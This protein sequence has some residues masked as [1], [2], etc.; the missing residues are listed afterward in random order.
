[1]NTIK[2]LAATALLAI[3]TQAAAVTYD[4]SFTHSTYQVQEGNSIDDLVAAHLAGSALTNQSLSGFDGIETTAFIAGNAYDHSIMMSTSFT[5]AE[6][7]QYE[8]QVGA[9]WGRGGGVAI[10]NDDTNSLVS[11]QIF[12]NDI[13]WSKNWNNSD[14]ISTNFE[15]SEGNWK[16][17]WVG[18]EGCCSG[19]TSIRFA[20]NGG[21]FSAL[22]AANFQQPHSAVVPI[23]GAAYF[24]ASAIALLATTAR[25]KQPL[26]AKD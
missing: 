25:K 7:T 13:W 17:V 4:I 9:D 19:S 23:P 2:A 15:F 18:F 11:E 26:P 5:L 20:E 10:Y 6:N 24:F 8:F 16:V 1:M 3:S 22:T 12:S 14:V 21:E